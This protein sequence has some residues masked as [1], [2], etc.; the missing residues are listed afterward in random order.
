MKF[1]TCLQSKFQNYYHKVRKGQ[2]ASTDITLYTR[3]GTVMAEQHEFRYWFDDWTVRP[4]KVFPLL[5]VLLYM[6]IYD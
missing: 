6:V 1:L 5:R 3:E 2:P 4:L